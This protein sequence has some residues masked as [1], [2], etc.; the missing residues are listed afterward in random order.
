MV[1]G[2]GHDA[3]SQECD[4]AQ[5][6]VLDDASLDVILNL[7]QKRI[8]DC[9]NEGR[10][11]G[12]KTSIVLTASGVLLAIIANAYG[13][14]E[15]V[16]AIICMGVIL[17]AAY[18]AISILRTEMEV[19]GIQE[20]WEDMS[21]AICDHKL[22]KLM[23]IYKMMAIE[24]SNRESLANMSIKWVYAGLALLVAIAVLAL[25]L[26]IHNVDFSF[27]KDIKLF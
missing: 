17:A 20:A 27:L 6:P 21:Q 24:K 10:S 16:T 2:N 5:G 1:Q 9:R 14:L 19:F 12:T 3:D 26:I 7:T 23:L 8:E 11:F 22:L 15:S 4:D 13:K 18:I 25:S